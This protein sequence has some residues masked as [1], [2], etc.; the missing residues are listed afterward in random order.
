[1]PCSFSEHRIAAY[2]DGTLSAREHERVSAH[3]ATCVRCAALLDEFRVVD[4]LLLMARTLEPAPNFTFR[5][6]AEIRT[7]PRPQRTHVPP[8]RIL[9]A[10]LAFAWI[11]IGIFFWLGRG[12]A[13]AALTVARRALVHA[14]DLVPV[15]SRIIAHVVGPNALRITTAMSLLVVLDVALFSAVA[16]LIY[17]RRLRRRS[18]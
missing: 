8:F 2:V 7:L 3:V 14:G 16:A 1:M 11:A 5:I 17:V 13:G 9:A 4:A 12:S 18:A 10:Y 6:M 15:L